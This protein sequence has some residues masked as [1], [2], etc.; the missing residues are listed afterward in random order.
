MKRTQCKR[1]DWEIKELFRHPHLYLDLG[2][3]VTDEVE[4]GEE[5]VP[6][7]LPDVVGLRVHVQVT[8][9]GHE[10]PAPE[11]RKLDHR[12][13]MKMCH[14]LLIDHIHTHT[15]TLHT[16]THPSTHA[17][18]LSLTHIPILTNRTLS[19]VLSSSL[20]PWR[21][22]SHTLNVLSSNFNKIC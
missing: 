4:V 8:L 19:L 7:V 6:L 13:V 22:H 20:S 3:F 1:E 12:S 17:N 9:L 10:L 15:C 14:L 5:L 2:V 21:L 16:H 18:T 11:Q